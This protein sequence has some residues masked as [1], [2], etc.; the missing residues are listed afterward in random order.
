M[1][2]NAQFLEL[3]EGRSRFNGDSAERHVEFPVGICDALSDLRASVS[4][5]EKAEHSR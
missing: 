5:K 1:T 3:T 2:C 4:K